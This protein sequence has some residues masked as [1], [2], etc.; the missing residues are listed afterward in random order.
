MKTKMAM[1]LSIIAMICPVLSIL[2]MFQIEE[3][4]EEALSFG[5]L[6][7]CILGSLA[8]LFALLLNQNRNKA[9]MVCSILPM[10]PLVLYITLAIPFILY[11]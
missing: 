5:L 8:G 11:R 3:E 4:F 9:I 2:I 1:V 7:G 6:T 10:C